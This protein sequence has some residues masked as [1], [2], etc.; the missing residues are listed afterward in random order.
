[1]KS[2]RTLVLFL[3]C[4]AGLFA[5]DADKR[6]SA[7]YQQAH[8]A[9]DVKAF[10]Q[11]IEF[12]NTT[13]ELTRTQIAEA[14]KNSL[15]R[16]IATVEVQDLA[17]TERTSYEVGGVAYVTTLPVVKKL[18]IAY[19]EEGQGPARVTNT[20]FLLGEKAGEYRIVSTMPKK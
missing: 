6:L 5:A 19:T 4:T 10:L 13:P 9:K 12:S 8:A 16:H 11:L 1:M 18:K 17:G 14:F 3:A 15:T 2:L 7:A 20:T